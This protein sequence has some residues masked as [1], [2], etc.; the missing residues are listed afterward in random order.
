MVVDDEPAVLDI[1]QRCLT[2]A[3]YRVFLAA[4]ARDA[5][6][7]C[8]EKEPDLILSDVSMPC[9]SGIEL[10]DCIAALSKPVP[11]ILM[12]GYPETSPEVQ[13][14]MDRLT[15]V[16]FLKKPFY[17]KQLTDMIAAALRETRRAGS[18]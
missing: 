8:H 14:L 16:S 2:G 7:L 17:P 13:R 1:V 12:S 6:N 3:G 11:M 15:G 10:A 4:N 18:G 5:L 9:M